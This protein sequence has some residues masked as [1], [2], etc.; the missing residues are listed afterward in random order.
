M[1][2]V[3]NQKHVN[4]DGKKMLVKEYFKQLAK[5]LPQMNFKKDGKEYAINHYEELLTVYRLKGVTGFNLY[6]GALRDVC[7]LE[8]AKRKRNIFKWIIQ[9]IKIIFRLKVKNVIE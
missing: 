1:K 7:K 8:T 5:T 6:M 2:I 4:V 3:F 9:K